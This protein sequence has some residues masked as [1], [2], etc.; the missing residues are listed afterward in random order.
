MSSIRVTYILAA[1][2]IILCFLSQNHVFFGDMVQFGSRHPHFFYENN[3]ESFWLPNELDSGHPP[4]FGMYIAAGWMIF[5]KSLIVSHWLML[6]FLLLLA[7]IIPKLTELFVDQKW[8]LPI[9]LLLFFEPTLLA[10]ASL[11][12]PDI[13]LISFFLLSIYYIVKKRNIKLSIALIPMSFIS[14]RGMM[15]LFAI[16]LGLYIYQIIIERKIFHSQ[17]KTLIYIFLPAVAINFSWLLAH[18]YLVGWIGFH[19]NSPWAS[20]FQQV[21]F[22]QIVKNIALMIWRWVDFGRITFWLIL[23]F[24]LLKYIKTLDRFSYKLISVFVS[25][26][27]VFTVN[28]SFADG[29]VGH[30]Y[31]MP[32]YLLG[33]LICIGLIQD[34]SSFKYLLNLLFISFIIGS[35]YIYPSKI[36]VGWD[37]TPAHF[38]YYELRTNLIKHL[39]EQEI[40]INN[41][42]S[43]FPNL[44]S[45]EILE[46]NGD[47]SKFQSYHLNNTEYIAWS[48]IFNYPDELIDQIKS[49]ELIYEEEKRGI[50]MRLYKIKK[51]DLQ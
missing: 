3:F 5:G 40:K 33:L 18:Y 4:I 47:T 42:A 15:V 22:G 43:G 1:L 34:R 14:M 23:I 37:A 17:T 28:T 6:P 36:A 35:I 51:S 13:V 21:G 16:F 26:I 12:S 45:R 25:L 2:Y 49:Y 8:V 20:S 41:V 39:N 48:N 46:L 44:D 32:I 50:F 9:S 10:Q 30:R 19:S 29:L 24:F 7:Y 11:T 27:I 31:Y 38:P